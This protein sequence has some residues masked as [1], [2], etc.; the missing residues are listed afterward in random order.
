MTKYSITVKKL[1]D[2]DK[3]EKPGKTLIRKTL[4]STSLEGLRVKV[5]KWIK[6]YKVNGNRWD[7]GNTIVTKN[8][9][10]LVEM[11]YNGRLWDLTNNE[12]P[13]K[14][15]DL[16]VAKENHLTDDNKFE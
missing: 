8:G 7:W 11:S 4:R 3:G 10:P 2:E 6:R 13:I 12:K 5:A 16:D 1:S 14:D 9:T 15:E